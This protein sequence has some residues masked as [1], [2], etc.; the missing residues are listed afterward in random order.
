M[1]TQQDAI[2]LCK[3][4]ENI[5]PRYGAHVALTGGCLYKEGARKDVD[6]HFYRIRQV[7]EVDWDG[8]FTHMERNGFNQLTP[9]SWVTKF[10]CAFTG[11]GIDIFDPEW[12]NGNDV[13]YGANK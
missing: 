2:A 9:R 4:L 12:K 13:N 3:S 10:E 5:A 1:W 8:L 7:D 6:I 11:R